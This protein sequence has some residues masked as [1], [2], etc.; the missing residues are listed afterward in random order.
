[1]Q[2]SG[3]KFPMICCSNFFQLPSLLCRCSAY[4]FLASTLC[5]VVLC[6]I[7]VCTVC[8]F[9]VVITIISISISIVITPFSPSSCCLLCLAFAPPRRAPECYSDH[10]CSKTRKGKTRTLTISALWIRGIDRS[11][12][13]EGPPFVTCCRFPNPLLSF[14]SLCVIVLRI[15]PVLIR[16]F[17]SIFFVS[18]RSF[19]RALVEPRG[20]KSFFS[21]FPWTFA[22]RTAANYPFLLLGCFENPFFCIRFTETEEFFLVSF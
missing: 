17:F 2:H 8:L 20:T 13:E 9:C 10:W 19:A 7:V 16:W 6:S 18:V 3:Y 14:F 11:D 21:Y 12:W 15:N 4:R 5:S 1:M 22:R